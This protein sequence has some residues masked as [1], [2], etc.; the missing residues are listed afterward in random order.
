MAFRIYDFSE[1]VRG[2][3]LAGLNMWDQ[4]EAHRLMNIHASCNLAARRSIIV[5]RFGVTS[6]RS[7]CVKFAA[8]AVAVPCAEGKL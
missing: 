6:I 4:E 8:K 1:K 7:A 3:E 5:S 2:S